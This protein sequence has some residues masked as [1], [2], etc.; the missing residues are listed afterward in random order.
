MS[1]FINR[2]GTLNLSVC[3]QLEKG[4]AGRITLACMIFLFTDNHVKSEAYHHRIAAKGNAY[5]QTPS[6]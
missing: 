1:A 3:L 6:V 2:A 4:D 5:L